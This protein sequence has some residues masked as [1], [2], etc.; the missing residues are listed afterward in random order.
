MA[1]VAA[2][3]GTPYRVVEIDSKPAAAAIY[4]NGVRRGVSKSKV[5]IEF[6]GDITQRS[7]VQLVKEG[8]RPV[9]QT[10]TIEEVPQTKT[11]TLE[12]E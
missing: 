9:F 8:Y 11:F 10:W 12:V 2:G 3:C 7:F 6:P 5:K 4:V 1:L